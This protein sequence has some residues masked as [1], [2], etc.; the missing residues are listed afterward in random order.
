MPRVSQ[1]QWNAGRQI[2]RADLQPGDLVFFYGD[3]HHVEIY[4]GNGQMIHTPR[5]GKNIELLPVDAMRSCQ[6]AVRP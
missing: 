4:V 1:S 3:L 5:T 2:A 6:G